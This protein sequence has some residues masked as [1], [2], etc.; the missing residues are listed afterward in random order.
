[1]PPPAHVS[2]G[3]LIAI[4]RIQRNANRWQQERSHGGLFLLADSAPSIHELLGVGRG[5][6]L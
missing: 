5:R 1:M 3:V 2:L 4:L 6:K